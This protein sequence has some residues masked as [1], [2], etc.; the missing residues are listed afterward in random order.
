MELFLFNELVIFKIGIFLENFCIK[1]VLFGEGEILN[2][3]LLLGYKLF[4]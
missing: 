3:L 4:V 1:I 2:F